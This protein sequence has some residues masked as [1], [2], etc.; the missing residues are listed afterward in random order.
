MIL[1]HFKCAIGLHLWRHF[2][3]LTINGRRHRTMSGNID[4]VSPTRTIHYQ[5]CECCGRLREYQKK[6][7]KK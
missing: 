7:G 4:V 1:R 5:R 3:S 2:D 6:K